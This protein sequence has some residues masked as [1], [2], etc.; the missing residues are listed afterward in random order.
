MPYKSE[1]Q[2][3]L[4]RAVAHGWHKPGGGGPSVEVAKKFGAED[5]KH[6]SGYA[7]GGPVNKGYMGKVESYA[8]GGPVLGRTRDF[9]KEPDR[10][11]TSGAPGR[12]GPTP[13]PTE[14]QYPKGSK[15][16]EGACK[17]LPPVKP[18]K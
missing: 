4:M 18:R 12:K 16:S 5:K 9:M 11:R 7:E 8:Q 1:A 10:F 6:P 3:R 14:D 15:H 13:E 17:E 2:A